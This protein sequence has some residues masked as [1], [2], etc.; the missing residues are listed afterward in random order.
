[1]IELNAEP[2]ALIY[3]HMQVIKLHG[4]VRFEVD[5]EGPKFYGMTLEEFKQRVDQSF[6]PIQPIRLERAEVIAE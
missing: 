3:G 4:K 5:P 1:V 6:V 2:G